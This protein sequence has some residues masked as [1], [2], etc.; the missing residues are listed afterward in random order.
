MPD[1]SS[2]SGSGLPATVRRPTT[3]AQTGSSRSVS[4]SIGGPVL[5][6]AEACSSGM[7]KSAVARS[8]FAVGDPGVPPAPRH[9]LL[10]QRLERRELLRLVLDPLPRAEEHRRAVVGRVVHR[11]PGKHEAVDQGGG[12]ADLAPRLTARSARLAAEPCR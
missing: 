2:A 9:Q 3:P 4:S 6:L 5:I 1:A 12:Q 11:R 10:D 7:R 8:S